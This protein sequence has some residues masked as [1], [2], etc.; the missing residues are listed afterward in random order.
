MMAF[1]PSGRGLAAVALAGIS[2]GCAAEN[3]YIEHEAWSRDRGPETGNW[4]EVESLFTAEESDPDRFR[5][6]LR[7][8]RHDLTLVADAKPERR[9][10]CLDVVVAPP[11]DPRFRWAADR[12]LVSP[13]HALIAVRTEGSECPAG[14]P[15]RRP[16][17]QA[18]DYVEGDVIVVV[19]SL[20]LERPQALGAIIERPAA[21][22]GLFVRPSDRRGPSA[23]FAQSAEPHG[24]CEILA[25]PVEPARPGAR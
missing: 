12:P 5:Y 9:C 10:A 22:R 2:L 18:V 7:G 4:R 13:R 11:N 14:P 16:S 17:I 24:M 1:R 21:G 8:V 15:A 23:V 25:R 19:E 6:T 20:P 3:A